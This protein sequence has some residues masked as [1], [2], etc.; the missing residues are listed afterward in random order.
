MGPKSTIWVRPELFLENLKK[1]VEVFNKI[2]INGFLAWAVILAI[3]ALL[4]AI[5]KL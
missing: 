2:D 4:G 3:T 5:V 1:F